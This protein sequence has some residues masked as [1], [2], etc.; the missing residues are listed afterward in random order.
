MPFQKAKLLQNF[1]FTLCILQFILP[2]FPKG[3]GATK[4]I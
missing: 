2:D 3:Y 4:T 1:Q